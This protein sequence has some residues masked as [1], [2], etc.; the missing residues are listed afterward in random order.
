M[1]FL[2]RRWALH[3]FAA[4]GTAAFGVLFYL[5]NA[6]GIY[7]SRA[8]L[9][10]LGIALPLFFLIAVVSNQWLWPIW[11][12]LNRTRRREALGITLAAL[13]AGTWLF[14]PPLPDFNQPLTLRIE[15]TG[16]QGILQQ[17]SQVQVDAV[18]GM[19]GQPIPLERFTR[20]GEWQV[21]KDG[22][23]VSDQARARLELQSQAPGGVLVFFH[24]TPQGGAARVTWNGLARSA[25]D[26]SA[27]WDETQPLVL[28]GPGLLALPFGQALLAAVL[29][30]LYLLGMAALTLAV[31]LVIFALAGPRAETVVFVLALAA[32]GLVFLAFK[33]TYLQADD[34]HSMG[35]T[36]SYSISAE[37][38]L[39]SKPFWAGKRSFTIPLAMKML[40]IS[41]SN[42]YERSVQIRFALFQTRFSAFSWLALALTLALA[43]AFPGRTGEKS[44]GFPG[45]PSRALGVA[46]YTATLAV[47]LSQ[48]ISLW[49]GLLLSESLAFSLLALMLAGWVGLVTWL[50]QIQSALLRW[51]C[52]GLTSLATLLYAFTRDSNGYFV[53]AGAALLAAAGFY[54]HRLAGVRRELLAYGAAGV[55]VFAALTL[56]MT[57]GNRWQ[58]FIY[59]RLG[60]QV[61]LDP[62][63]TQF[64]ADQGLPVNDQL[65]QITS[66]RGSVYQKLIDES[67]DFAPVKAWV[68]CCGKT[69]YAHYLLSDPLRTLTQPFTVWRRLVDGGVEGYRH[70]ANDIEPL[71]EHVFAVNALIFNHQGGVALF[72]AAVALLATL[73]AFD[74]RAGPL[75][76]FVAVL[77]LPIAPMM[78]VI[79][80]GEPMEIERHAVQLSVQLR[81]AGLVGLFWL[82]QVIFQKFKKVD[83]VLNSN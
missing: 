20:Q 75:P 57:I 60:L 32:I 74:R 69:A 27:H 40:G 83:P 19:D 64:F 1:R 29:S 4:L 34:A 42:Y 7:P 10:V 22:G 5:K 79:W 18:V 63:A 61:L 45:A 13:L 73:A 58:V 72:F 9:A 76:F 8:A 59:D 12:G 65:L 31:L 81:L 2:L 11:Q 56:S 51:L 36:V 39:T 30:G 38:P 41:S 54:H 52:L 37:L 66:M 55:L 68:N 53:L 3:L 47:G 62:Q 43:A 28:R 67:P 82:V 26:L 78:F 70:A 71:P 21:T 33:A 25:M 49:D 6:Y 46:L 24:Y 16:E 14:A 17:G 77:A 15:S 80:F 50:P 35:D 48:T 44:G 23:L